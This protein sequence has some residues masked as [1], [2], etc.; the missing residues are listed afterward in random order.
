MRQTTVNLVLGNWDAHTKNVSFLYEEPQA[1]TVVPLYDVRPIAEAEPCTGVL[2]MHVNGHIKPN[3]VN[4][5]DVVAETE[6]WGMSGNADQQS[7]G[8]SR[9][10]PRGSCRKHS[11]SGES[12]HGTSMNHPPWI[13]QQNVRQADRHTESG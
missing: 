3:D 9:K 11:H 7:A 1:P 2:S 6:S 5:K 10:A 4:D 13:T 8:I 12:R